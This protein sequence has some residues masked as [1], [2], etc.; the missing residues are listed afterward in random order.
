MAEESSEYQAIVKILKGAVDDKAADVFLIPGIPYSYRIDGEIISEGPD[1]I[2]PMQMDKLIE[3]IYKIAKRSMQKAQETGDDD[4]SFSLPGISRY[5]VSVFRQRG[6]FAAIIRVVSFD[7]P[8]IADLHIPPVVLDASKLTKGMVLVTGPAGSGKSTTLAC[9]IDRINNT[10]NAHVITLEDPI[11]YLHKHKKSVVTQREIYTDTVSYSTGLRAALR[12]SPDVVLLG[13]MRD[14]ETIRTAMTAAETGHLV[15]STVHTLGA[16]NT[17]N[18]LV[19]IFPAEQQAQIRMQIS[20]VMEMIISQQL[21]QTTDG[22]MIPAFE[23]MI[24]NS[25]IRTMIREGNIQRIDSNIASG[26]AEGMISMED[27][28]M[29]LYRQGIITEE[30]CIVHAQDQEMMSKKLHRG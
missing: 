16:S 12:Q 17:I 26:K 21:I 14:F 30:A 24:L 20:M 29:D 27:S 23:V 15:I 10:R 22:K 5:R 2:L 18:R 4:F 25:A 11:E 13:E 9:I 3:Q 28:L 19:D 8:K 6:S 1:K 7:L